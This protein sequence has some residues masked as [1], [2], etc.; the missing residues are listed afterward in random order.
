MAPALVNSVSSLAEFS[1][2]F[3]KV[4]ASELL[5]IDQDYGSLEVGK[6]AD[7]L[8]LKNNPL[9]DVSYFTPDL[10]ALPTCL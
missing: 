1:K 6:Y 10:I 5:H 7:F 9:R 3:L 2:V 8:V 4:P